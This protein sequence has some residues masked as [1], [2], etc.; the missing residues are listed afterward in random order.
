[1]NRSLNLKLECLKLIKCQNN[2]RYFLFR[3]K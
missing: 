3:S 2:L 1:M